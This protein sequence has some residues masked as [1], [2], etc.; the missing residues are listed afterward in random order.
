MMANTIARFAVQEL[1]MPSFDGRHWLGSDRS[2]PV[3]GVTLVDA[4][5]RATRRRGTDASSHASRLR[6]HCFLS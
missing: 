5:G 4:S 6:L 1:A 2:S 3:P